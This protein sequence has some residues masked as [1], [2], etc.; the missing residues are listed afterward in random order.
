MSRWVGGLGYFISLAGVRV[1]WIQIGLV[2][3]VGVDRFGRVLLVSFDESCLV[4]AVQ[5]AKYLYLV[6]I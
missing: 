2:G 6:Y 4:I 5:L 1:T 3:F